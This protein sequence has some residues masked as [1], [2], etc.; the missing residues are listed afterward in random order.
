MFGLSPSPF[1][2]DGDIKHHLGWYKEDQPKTV[3]NLKQSMYVND[4]IG[5]RGNLE[6]AKTFKENIVEI[7]NEAGFKLHKWRSNFGELEEAEGVSQKETDETYAKQ[8]LSK[9]DT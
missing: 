1:V 8:Q 7:F 5:T 6:P 2:L 3:I 9:R 4:V